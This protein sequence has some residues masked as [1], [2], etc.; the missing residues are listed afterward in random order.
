MPT[1]FIFKAKC[2]EEKG[3]EPEKERRTERKLQSVSRKSIHNTRTKGA[4]S[5]NPVCGYLSPCVCHSVLYSK[6]E[7][8]KLVTEFQQTPNVFIQRELVSEDH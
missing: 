6:L 7:T 4:H 3:N 2:R 5:K 8:S 1:N